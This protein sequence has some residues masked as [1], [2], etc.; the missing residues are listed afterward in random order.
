MTL[1]RH[2]TLI[3]CIHGLGIAAMLV[4]TGALAI[5]CDSPAPVIYVRNDLAT[6]A[7]ISVTSSD[8]FET[9]LASSSADASGSRILHYGADHRVLEFSADAESELWLE[10]VLGPDF[11]FTVTASTLQNPESVLVTS[12][13]VRAGIRLVIDSQG[14]HVEPLDP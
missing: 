9:A 12:H 3:R 11:T 13:D 6:Q 2:G 14:I 7:T 1:E 5:G 8:G 10:E 4:I